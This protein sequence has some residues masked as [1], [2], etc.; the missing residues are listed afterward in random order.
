MFLFI[1]LKSVVNQT[2]LPLVGKW[3]TKKRQM[4]QY[5]Y[6]YIISELHFQ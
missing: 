1:S 4:K 5:Y 2:V 3:V 6:H